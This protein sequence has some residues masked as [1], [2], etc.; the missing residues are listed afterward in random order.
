MAGNAR[1]L[2]GPGCWPSQF[3]LGTA[4]CQ[5]T[6]GVTATSL[7]REMTAANQFFVTEHS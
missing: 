1:A 7:Q 3:G 5:L 4:F 6:D 2:L